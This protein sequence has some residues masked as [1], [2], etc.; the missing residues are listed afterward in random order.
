MLKKRHWLRTALDR[1][2]SPRSPPVGVGDPQPSYLSDGSTSS[3]YP[4]P[5][6]VSAT[7]DSWDS[8][9][10]SFV[11]LDMNQDPPPPTLTT[12]L[13]TPDTPQSGDTPASLH[14]SASPHPSGSELGPSEGPQESQSGRPASLPLPASLHD[15]ASPQASNSEPGPSAIQLPEEPQESQVERPQSTRL[16]PGLASPLASHSHSN[17]WTSVSDIPDMPISD[18]LRMFQPVPGGVI[19]P[20]PTGSNQATT[21]AHPPPDQSTPEG[22]E[23]SHHLTSNGAPAPPSHSSL[24]PPSDV[25]FFDERFMKHAVTAAGGVAALT[26]MTASVMGIIEIIHQ[27][28]QDN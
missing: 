27:S 22:M 18:R 12:P 3:G 14:D 15:S 8:D 20:Q 19:T 9:Y 16:P 25:N 24:T 17:S 7:A 11:P 6:R 26:V 28:Q 13:L 23:L 1:S 10:S 5:P 21:E 2:M 4:G